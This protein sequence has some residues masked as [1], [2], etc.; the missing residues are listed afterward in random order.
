MPAY[1]AQPGCLKLEL[2]KTSESGSYL[3]L[4]YWDKRSS[5]DAWAGA[6]G[7]A[8]RDRNRPVLERWLEMMAF[9]AE[10]DAEE[11]VSG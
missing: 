8:W 1:K 10:W 11:V 6:S 3:A 2:L 5:F 9:Q 7:S 4:T